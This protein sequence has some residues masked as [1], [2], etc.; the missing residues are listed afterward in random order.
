MRYRGLRGALNDLFTSFNLTN[1]DNKL[2]TLSEKSM[3]GSTFFQLSTESVKSLEDCLKSLDERKLEKEEK[4]R[5]NILISGLVNFSIKTSNN[6]ERI[7]FLL[8]DDGFGLMLFTLLL[9]QPHLNKENR[10]GW[11]RSLRNTVE[12]DVRG[13]LVVLHDT[14]SIAVGEIKTSPSSFPSAK[15]QLDLS[16]SLVEAA[17]IIIYK[18]V[19]HIHIQKFIFVPADSNEELNASEGYI[20]SAV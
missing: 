19:K 8:N 5:L 12:M 17:V 16:A 3:K 2:I 18:N 4:L 13:R 9:A 20:V 7:R 14:V 1:G 15:S 11:L 6:K 10:K